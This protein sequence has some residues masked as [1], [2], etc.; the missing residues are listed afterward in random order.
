MRAPTSHQRMPPN[1]VSSG[2]AVQAAVLIR[3]Q[4]ISERRIFD[5][6]SPDLRRSA[7]PCSPR[8]EQAQCAVG[9]VVLVADQQRQVGLRA[10]QQGDVVALR[11]A[12]AT[13]NVAIAAVAEAVSLCA[14]STAVSR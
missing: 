1:P 7:R 10:L 6:A 14:F 12:T 8:G 11:A 13:F 2:P 9:R 3:S 5:V 4:T